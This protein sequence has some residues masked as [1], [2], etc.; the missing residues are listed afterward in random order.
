[1][2]VQ[3]DVEVAAV[4]LVAV[5][6]RFDVDPPVVAL[7]GVDLCVAPGSLT[8]VLGPSGSGKTT[9][10]R[11]L[12][13]TER[14]DSGTVRIGGATLDAPGTHVP[15]ERRRVGLVPQ[16]GALF[17]H[18]DVAGNVAF[19]LPRRSRRE[20]SRRVAELL[21]LVDL[22][23]IGHR[24][25]HELSGGQQQRVAL[26]RALAPAPDVVL[27]DEPFSAL[28]ASLRS[29][30]RTEVAD[31]LRSTGTTAVLVTHDQDEAMSVADSLAVLRAGRIVQH[32]PPDELYRRPAD[33]WVAG[34]LGD[35]VLLDAELADGVARCALGELPVDRA[36]APEAG[37]VTVFLRPEQ[38][39]P[40]GSATGVVGEVAGTRFAGAE[41]E[42]ALV[43][44]GTEVAARWP[45][46]LAPVRAGDRV[47]LEVLGRPVA[48]PART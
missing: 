20:R 4:E 48:Y 14:P 30:L 19:G 33:L 12:A 42:V 32:G 10:L 9:L 7:D 22:Q 6:R 38:V 29:S 36:G 44:D 43:V 2:A 16:E 18:L 41:V 37:A 1:M 13:G 21:E 47:D 17:P 39:W 34:F 25:P 35:A 26:A 3:P 23:G 46:S 40:A 5:R 15:P 24:R 11:V 27:L 8:A 45:S 28:D 31:L